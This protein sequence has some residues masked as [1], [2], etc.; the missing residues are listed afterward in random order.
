MTKTMQM[1]TRAG[2]L[3]WALL[4]AGCGGGAVTGFGGQPVPVD[5]QQVILASSDGRRAVNLDNRFEPV[6]VLVLRHST[7]W[8]YWA[9]NPDARTLD[10]LQNTA[11]VADANKKTAAQETLRLSF[12]LLQRGEHAAA[13]R[14]FREAIEA[15]QGDN[16][17]AQFYF[18]ESALAVG[19]FIDAAEAYR[20]VIALAPNGPDALLARGRINSLLRDPAGGLP[21][22]VFAH[23]TN[24]ET[25]MASFLMFDFV[26]RRSS[27]IP[28]GRNRYEAMLRSLGA[29]NDQ[30]IQAMQ[31][32]GSRLATRD[33]NNPAD[34]ETVLRQHLQETDGFIPKLG[35]LGITRHIFNPSR[36]QCPLGLLIESRSYMFPGAFRW[37]Q[38]RVRGG[39]AAPGTPEPRADVSFGDPP[40]PRFE[41][42][43]ALN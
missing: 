14:G 37:W 31:I 26:G 34:T 28:N 5:P 23:A 4:L 36:P 19:R 12:D 22:R 39:P 40:I 32:Y 21:E 1:A 20:N 35:Y 18:A 16:P 41:D 7:D 30:V 17:Q 29:S 33:I 8:R 11:Q 25:C 27:G 9:E 10:R 43:I 42:R 2:L 38:A 13:F 24:L 3:A 6:Q 15:G